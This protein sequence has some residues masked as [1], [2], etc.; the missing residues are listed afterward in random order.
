MFVDTDCAMFVVVALKNVIPLEYKI[1]LFDEAVDVAVLYKVA[2]PESVAKN[3]LVLL[4]ML[5]DADDDDDK[6]CI[7]CLFVSV[8]IVIHRSWL[9]NP[10]CKYVSS[11]NKYVSPAVTDIFVV[12]VSCLV[13]VY[14]FVSVPLLLSLIHI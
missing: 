6:E 9:K 3:R 2:V 1:M 5:C 7:I 4:P 14:P 12:S 10:C 13:V 11:R 8:P